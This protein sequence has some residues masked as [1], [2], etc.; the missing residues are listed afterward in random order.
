AYAYFIPAQPPL[1]IVLD[2]KDDC[3]VR[4]ALAQKVFR[5][6]QPRIRE[7]RRSRHALAVDQRALALVADYA[8]EIPD[9]GPE[10]RPVF[11]G[12]AVQ[13]AVRFKGTAVQVCRRLRKGRQG[14]GRYP[15]AGW[16]PQRRFVAHSLLL[17]LRAPAKAYRG[18]SGQAYVRICHC[19]ATKT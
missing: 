2:A 1:D 12:P 15:V 8:A 4:A 19:R 6:V 9:Q 3:G 14:R 7:K 13:I 18:D 16:D 5:K 17:K 11:D 10:R